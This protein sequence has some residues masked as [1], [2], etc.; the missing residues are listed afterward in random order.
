MDLILGGSPEQRAFKRAWKQYG[1]RVKLIEE[2]ESGLASLSKEELGAKTNE[3]R[4]RYNKEKIST[5]KIPSGKFK[6]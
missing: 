3:F 6:I 1:P 2:L 5:F 4:G